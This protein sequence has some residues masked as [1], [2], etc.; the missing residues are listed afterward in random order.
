MTQ[1]PG[2]GALT[3]RAHDLH[4]E[5]GQAAGGGQAQLDHA[6]HRDGV[7]VQVVEERA[8]LVVV[9]HQPQLSPRP[10]ICKTPDREGQEGGGGGGAGPIQTGG[11]VSQKTS[12]S[13]CV[14]FS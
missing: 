12:V 1:K 9:G 7:A 8:V 13:R 5:V 11:G 3:L 10:V 2:G 14:S 4:V 6:L